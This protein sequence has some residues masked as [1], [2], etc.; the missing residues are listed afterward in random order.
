M[1]IFGW[2]SSIK[3][4]Y[5]SARSPATYFTQLWN[6]SVSFM[7]KFLGSQRHGSCERPLPRLPFR[8]RLGCGSLRA[9]LPA[10]RVFK[11]ETKWLEFAVLIA[12]ALLPKTI[13]RWSSKVAAKQSVFKRAVR[14]VESTFSSSSSHAT[15]SIWKLETSFSG[16]MNYYSRLKLKRERNWAEK[17]TDWCLFFFFEKASPTTPQTSHS[18]EL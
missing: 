5:W 4:S 17:L 18:I 10:R 12:A 14:T 8:R 13:R 11:E 3:I 6:Q 2:L 9:C 15:C 16:L 7:I 1:S